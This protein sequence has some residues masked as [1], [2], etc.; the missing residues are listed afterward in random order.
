MLGRFLI[1]FFFKWKL[2]DFQITWANILFTWE[3]REHNKCLNREIIYFYP[4]NEL[5][6]NLMPATVLKKV[7]T[8]ATKG[9]KRHFEKI[10]LGEQLAT[11]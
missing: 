5:I 2:K 1:R 8:G 10:Q 4:L 3:Q 7:G 11:N 9:C 6:S